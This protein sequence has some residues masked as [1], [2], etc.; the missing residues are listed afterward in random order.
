MFDEAQLV[1]SSTAP[2]DK[3]IGHLFNQVGDVE[4]ALMAEIHSH[5]L[6]RAPIPEQDGQV[7]EP[8]LVCVSQLKVIDDNAPLDALAGL[9]VSVRQ[10]TPERERWHVIHDCCCLKVIVIA[11]DPGVEVDDEDLVKPWTLVDDQVLD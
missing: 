5:I 4:E 1:A 11:R 3:D 7:L 2:N 10:I 8:F 6:V 9:L